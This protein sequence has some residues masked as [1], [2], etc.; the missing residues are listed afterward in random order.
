MTCTNQILV[1]VFLAELNFIVLFCMCI[2]CTYSSKYNN[3][4]ITCT[5]PDSNPKPLLNLN[6]IALST[7]LGNALHVLENKVQLSFPLLSL[8][9]AKLNCYLKYMNVVLITVQNVQ[10]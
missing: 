7:I 9:F 1:T 2:L 8:A 10:I 4:V 3:C 6:L 5:N